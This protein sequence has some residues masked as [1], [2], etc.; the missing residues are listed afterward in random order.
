MVHTNG[1]IK[2]SGAEVELNCGGLA[3]DILENNF[4]MS[5]R[6]CFYDILMKNMAAFC[7]CLKSLHEPKIKRLRLIAFTKEI[8]VN[9]V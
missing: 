7:P 5:S 9:Q 8:Q 1:N 3:Q 4:C 2:D 6:E